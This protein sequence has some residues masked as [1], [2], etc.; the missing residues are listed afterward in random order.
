[1]KQNIYIFIILGFTFFSCQKT[2][3]IDN[4]EQAPTVTEADK[5]FADV[6]KKL[7]GKWKG[8]FIVIKDIDPLLATSIDLKNLKLDYVTKPGLTLMNNIE[9]E[10]TYVSESPYFQKVD[11]YDYYPKEKKT[12]TSRGVNKIQDG[13]M[14]CVVKKP[15]ETIIHEGSIQNDSTIIWQSHQ[16]QPQK[17]EYFQETVTDKYYEII[18]YGYYQDDRL[19]LAPETWFYGKYLKK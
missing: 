1:M 19:D 9:V 14:W 3:E 17:I 8:N 11:I 2:I 6:Y 5:K 4:I 16:E 13:K 10:Q 7:D 18:G 12:I 15:N